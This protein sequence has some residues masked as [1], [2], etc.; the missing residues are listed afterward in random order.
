MK[1]Y[2]KRLYPTDLTDAQWEV[3]QP[4]LPPAKATG[5]PRELARRLIINAIFYVVVGGIQWRMLP[6]EYPNWQSV[7]SYFRQWREDGTWQRLHDTLHAHERER[8][9]RHKHPTAGCL[10]SQSVKASAGVGDRGYDAGKQVNGRKRHLLV[11]TLGLVLAVVVTA[12]SV[13]DRDG[14]RLLLRRLGGACK[15]LRLIWV[16]GNYRGQLLD[17]VAKRF[18]FLLRPVRRCDD[19]KGFIILPRRWVVE[20][21]F[22]W[23]VANRRLSKDYE[24]LPASSEAM[25]YIAMTRLMLRRLAA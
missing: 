24:R 13:Q 18:R 22:G 2:Q 1:V 8:L 9:G 11:D 20:R 6:R 16:D 25:I 14:A 5:R 3:L 7:Y 4:L 17:W 12:A 21:T 15:K 23:L 19:Q 10:D